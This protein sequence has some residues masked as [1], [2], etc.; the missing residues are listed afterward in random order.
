MLAQ[1]VD[2]FDMEGHPDH[3]VKVYQDEA[4]FITDPKELMSMT[5]DGTPITHSISA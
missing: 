3:P 2:M 1:D 4:K 5:F